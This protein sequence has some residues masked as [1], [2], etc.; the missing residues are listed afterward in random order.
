MCCPALSNGLDTRVGLTDSAG[1]KTFQRD[2]VGVTA[3][4]LTDGTATFTASGEN[5]GGVK[6][7]FSSALKNTDLQTSATGAVTAERQYD[8]FGNVIASPGARRSR[9]GNAGRFG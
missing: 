4:V 6:T 1:T 2:G 9:C 7:T 5:R 8:A 3:P